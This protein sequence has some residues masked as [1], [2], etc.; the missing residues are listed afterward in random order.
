MKVNISNSVNKKNPLSI[1]LDSST[2]ANFGECLPIFSHELPPNTH[3]ALNIRDAVRF[4]PLSFPT[5]GKAYLNTYAFSHKISKLYPP[6]NDLLGRTPYTSA[7]GSIYVPTEVPSVPLFLLWLSVLSNCEFTF[8]AS[9]FSGVHSYNRGNNPF[10]ISSIPFKRITEIHKADGSDLTEEDISASLP[11]WLCDALRSGN[12]D[13]PAQNGFKEAGYFYN[14]LKTKDTRDRL[15]YSNDGSNLSSVYCNRPE[16]ETNPEDILHRNPVLPSSADYIFYLPKEINYYLYKDSHGNYVSSEIGNVKFVADAGSTDYQDNIMVCIRLND[17][18]KFLRKI[19]MGLGY[20]IAP[21]NRPVSILP[22]YAYFMSYFETFAPKRFVKFEQTFFAR[23]INAVVNS[24][25]TLSNVILSGS[26]SYDSSVTWSNVLDDLLS[27]YYTKDTDY[28]SSQ[29]IGLINDYGN[30]ISQKY[31]GVYSNPD[32][33]NALEVEND[34]LSSDVSKGVVPSIDFKDKQYSMNHTQNQQNILSRLTQFVNRRSVI[35]SKL[36]A[37][38]KSVFGISQKDV[39]DYNFRIGSSSIDVNFSDVFSTAETAEGSLGE[40]AGKAMAFGNGET[41]HVET[42]THTIVLAFS[43]IVPRTQYVQGVSPLLSHIKADDFYNPMFDGLTLLPTRKSNLYCGNGFLTWDDNDKS[44]GN[45]PIYSEYKTKTCGV[46]TGDLSL[47]STKASYDSFTMDELISD[48]T[49]IKQSGDIYDGLYNNISY[50]P[51][52]LVAGTMWRYLGRWLWLG[53]FDRIFVNNRVN[54]SDFVGSILPT[55]DDGDIQS[56]RNIYR[57][58]DNLVVHHVVDMKLNSAVVPLRGTW[59]TDDMLSL[60]SNG[61][62]V[63]G[64]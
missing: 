29:I 1:S 47:N 14:Y 42:S 56:T 4:A 18:G 54:W 62:T 27:C 37:L 16:D 15:V 5:F 3:M 51:N 6:F 41:Y 53:R 59:L 63:Q 19:F 21:L 10:Y 52:G 34:S 50:N 33:K 24:G 12:P 23:L 20:Q 46:L 30:D 58:D 25:N 22:L 55:E 28:Y 61:V 44:F 45:S 32:N 38:L 60:D 49:Y 35:G 57:T 11:L 64:E 13:L 31:L 26:H 36:S 2:T 7:S 43:V 8:Y 17:S 39:D 9:D 40:Y 48:F